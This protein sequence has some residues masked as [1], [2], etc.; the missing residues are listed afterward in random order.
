MEGL[1]SCS[2]ACHDR[3]DAGPAAQY[4]RRM[5]ERGV[6]NVPDPLTMTLSCRRKPAQPG[7]GLRHA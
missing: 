7:H 3:Q 2:N 6:A 1:L 4:A 5:R